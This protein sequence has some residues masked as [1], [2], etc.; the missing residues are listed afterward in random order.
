MNNSHKLTM[1][2][3]ALMLAAA[4]GHA[5]SAD[6]FY[7]DADAGRALQQDVS[8]KNNSDLGSGGNVRFDTGFRAGVDFGYNF[9]DSFAAQLE[10]GV[11]RNTINQF[12]VQQLSTFGAKAELDEIP[13]LVNFI[14]KFPVGNF[15][16][17]VGVG[18]GGVAGIFDS[19]NIPL[20]GG[21]YNDTDFTF[22]CQAEA[23]FKY[24]LSEHI[25]LGLAYKFMGTTEHTWNDNSIS[26]KTDGTMTHAIEATFTWSF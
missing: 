9:N 19:S 22:A 20:S 1:A 25:S 5:Q 16:P 6:K 26:L 14:Y 15:K 10:T 12:G 11:I 8:I 24:S 23:G 4:S 21:N 3:A 18:V 17:Y 13:L 7:L 2:G